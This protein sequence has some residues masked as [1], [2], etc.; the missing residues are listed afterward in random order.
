MDC[1]V[2]GMS[3]KNANPENHGSRF[4]MS[5]KFFRAVDSLCQGH[6]TCPLS[7]IHRYFVGAPDRVE[8]IGDLVGI[9]DVV[10]GDAHVLDGA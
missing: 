9:A 7:D 6:R 1:S 8:Q 10:D 2:C 3:I 5:G 4:R